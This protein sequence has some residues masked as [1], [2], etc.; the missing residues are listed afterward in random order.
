MALPKRLNGVCRM[1]LEQLIA[2]KRAKAEQKQNVVSGDIGTETGLNTPIQSVPAIEA[3][4]ELED[5]SRDPDSIIIQTDLI[6]VNIQV[7]ESFDPQR[8]E[9]LAD[10]IAAHGQDSA[11]LVRPAG[12]GRYELVAGERRFRAKKI[13]QARQ[14]DHI[15]HRL[16][17]ATTKLLNDEQKENRQLAENIHRDELKPLELAKALARQKEIYGY[18]D[19]QLAEKI[20][21]DR[22]FVSRY[23]GLINL[24]PELQYL[25]STDEIKPRPAL[26]KKD[27]LVADVVAAMPHDLQAKVNEG[28]LSTLAALQ[29]RD[30]WQPSNPGEDE[31]NP[32]ID[33]QATESSASAAP[34]PQATKMPKVSVSLDTAEAMGELLTLIAS[35]LGLN[36][37]Q[38]TK[39]KGRSVRKELLVALDSRA[40]DILQAY[41]QR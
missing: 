21:K 10:D 29:M 22:S 25:I 19:A 24:S 37:V 20:K 13:L 1:S 12:N 33:H 4:E 27:K 23:L 7:R 31:V 8:L 32:D 11:I 39:Q 41:R 15:E 3:S 9:D 17:R 16:I 38:V 36:S 34:K 6:D 28:D 26:E 18:T 14:P 35:D 2:D 30:S 40:Q 5:F